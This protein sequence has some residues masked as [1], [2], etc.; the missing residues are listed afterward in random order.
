MSSVSMEAVGP[1]TVFV[2]GY[3]VRNM[4]WL[5]LLVGL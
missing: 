2:K 1:D 5:G 4:D 3:I